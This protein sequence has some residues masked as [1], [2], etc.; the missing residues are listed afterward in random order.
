MAQRVSFAATSFL[1]PENI[2]IEIRASFMKTANSRNQILWNTR[3]SQRN[4]IRHK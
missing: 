3:V 4:C 2:I 1:I